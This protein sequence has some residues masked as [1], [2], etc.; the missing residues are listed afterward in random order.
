MPSD[1]Q[2]CGRLTEASG[3]SPRAVLA[4]LA[5]ADA[6]TGAQL[7]RGR[8]RRGGVRLPLG[9]ASSIQGSGDG[10]RKRRPVLGQPDHEIP[11]GD[12][13]ELGVPVRLGQ[14]R[15]MRDHAG[16]DVIALEQSVAVE[17][18]EGEPRQPR[19]GADRSLVLDDASAV[20]N[21]DIVK[22]RERPRNGRQPTR[23]HDV[24]VVQEKALL[25]LI[26]K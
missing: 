1:V 23:E 6:Q 8:V 5:L 2:R 11:V 15:A 25:L 21:V 19:I 9:R 18:T 20:E 3:A 17:V 7:L 4:R 14:A 24:V 13:G 12:A 26:E 16:V 22:P 10:K